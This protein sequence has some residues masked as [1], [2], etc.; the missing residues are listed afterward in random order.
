MANTYFFLSKYFFSLLRYGAIACLLGIIACN[1]GQKPNAN[2]KEFQEE[3]SV[4]STTVSHAVGFDIEKRNES[5]VL[6][7]F[8]HYNDAVDTLSYLLRER[9]SPNDVHKIG[10]NEIVVPLKKIALLHSSYLA[11]FDILEST[12]ALVA[13]SESKYVYDS[14]LYA[15]ISGNEIHQVGYGETLDKEKLLS[16]DVG[17]VVTVG[18]PNAP[19]KSKQVLEELGLPVLILS[20]WQETTLLGRLEWIKVIGVLTGKESLADSLFTSIAQRY[21]DLQRL[22]K[23]AKDTPDV[24]CNL[25][26]KGSWYMPGGDSYVSNVIQDAG[27]NYLWSDHEGTGGIQIA[28]EAVYAKGTTADYWINPGFAE[29]AGEIIGKDER[30]NDFK[31]L[32]LGNIYNNNKRISRSKAN[33]YWESGIVRPDLILA[34]LIKVF[35]PELVPRHEFYYYKNLK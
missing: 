21:T 6:H 33:D 35:H 19:N 27:A 1:P 23:L 2:H 24:I 29:S 28:F 7:F 20:E 26:Y 4:L 31:A 11:Y 13:I 25:P 14:G 22:A 17:A 9:K 30:L 12:D 16:L 18:W 8:R 34:D 3:Q 15:S 5:K 10:V 32:K